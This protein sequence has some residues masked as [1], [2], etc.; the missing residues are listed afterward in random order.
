[1]L[2]LIMFCASVI[3]QAQTDE[4]VLRIEVERRDEAAIDAAARQALEQALLQRS[5]DRALLAHPSVSRALDSARSQLARYQF[6]QV[7]S[8]TRFVAHIDQLALESL[9]RSASGTIWAEERPPVLLWLVVD[10]AVGRRFGNLAPERGLWEA[11]SSEF[12]TLGMN[13]RR[14]L[15]DLSDSVLVS[16][17]TLWR[18]DYGPVVEASDRYGMTHLLIGRLIPLSNAR[19]IGEWT[20][21][22]GSTERSVTVQAESLDALIGPGVQL[23]MTEMRRQYAVALDQPSTTTPIRISVENVVSLADY[24][25]VTEAISGVRTLERVRPV[26]VNGDILVLDVFG[27]SEPQTL[28]RLMASRTDLQWVVTDPEQGLVMAWRN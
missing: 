20:Y 18:K 23:A 13:L 10:D 8:K 1:M 3:G 5:G 14:P 4:L 17:E 26:S 24:Q 16:P 7:D 11:I 27:I 22:D 12:S 25:G 21:R 28:V 6:E 19:F 15:Y 9:I 2:V